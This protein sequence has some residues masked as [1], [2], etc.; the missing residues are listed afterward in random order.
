MR[1]DNAAGGDWVGLFRR[2][3]AAVEEHTGQLRQARREGTARVHEGM[4]SQRGS[5]GCTGAEAVAA[6]V[7][8]GRGGVSS[9]RRWFVS[10]KGPR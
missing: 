8:E 4:E 10:E 6:V 1:R 3:L 7:S 9:M 2:G 5:V